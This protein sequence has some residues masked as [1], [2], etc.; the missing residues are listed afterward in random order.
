MVELTVLALSGSLREKS[1]NM[2]ALR[3]AGGLMPAG[4][5]L[6][7]TTIAD[8]PLYNLDIQDKGFPAPVDRLSLRQ[9]R[10]SDSLD[11]D[12]RDGRADDRSCSPR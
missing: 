12:E 2:M 7:I 1:Y 9:Q 3:I 5:K 6:K 11:S 8:L 10:C 4:M